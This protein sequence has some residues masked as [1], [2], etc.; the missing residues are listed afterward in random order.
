[1]DHPFFFSFGTLDLFFITY[2][3]LKER[4]PDLGLIIFFVAI[5][6]LLCAVCLYLASRN[7]GYIPGFGLQTLVAIWAG[8]ANCT[9]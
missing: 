7:Y 2:R 6:A 1:M 8:N 3:L 5:G 4:D 9:E